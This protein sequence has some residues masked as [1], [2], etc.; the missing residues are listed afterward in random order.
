MVF[1]RNLFYQEVTSIPKE[2]DISEKNTIIDMFRNLFDHIE[3][4]QK[5]CVIS[6]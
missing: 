5:S 6:K 2:E 1:Q 4:T 3:E